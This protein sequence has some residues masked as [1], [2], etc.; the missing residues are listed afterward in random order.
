VTIYSRLSSFAY[1]AVDSLYGMRPNANATHWQLPGVQSHKRWLEILKA[2]YQQNGLYDA[3]GYALYQ[4]GV[5]REALKALRVAGNAAVEFY[6]DTV[7]PGTLPEALPFE[8]DSPKAEQISA[9]IERVWEWSGW[10]AAKQDFVATAAA[11]GDAFTKIVTKTD[12]PPE[13]RRVEYELLDTLWV[14]DFDAD[15]RGF[16]TWIRLDIPTDRRQPDGKLKTVTHTEVWE[17][18]VF[19]VDANSPSGQRR[20]GRFRR[21]EH[22][23]GDDDIERLG[24]PL[25]DRPI[26][27]FGSDSVPVDFIPIGRC[28]FKRRLREKWGVGCYAHAL[29]KL[30]E[31]DRQGTHLYQSLFRNLD[32]QFVL[33]S[34]NAIVDG[35]PGNTPPPKMAGQNNTT[36]D[37]GRLDVGGRR[38]ARV[39]GGWEYVQAIAQLQYDAALNILQ[40]YLEGLKTDLPELRYYDTQDGANASGRA[41]RISLTPAIRRAIEARANIEEAFV[42]LN[43]MALTMGKAIGIPSFQDVGEYDRG[44]FAHRFKER[45]VLPADELEDAQALKAKYEGLVVKTE[46]LKAATDFELEAD[47]YTT[48][49]IARIKREREASAEEA[50]ER[51][52]RALEAA[53]RLPASA[54][55]DTEAEG[56]EA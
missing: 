37:D 9:A 25:E 26:S 2:V 20:I 43:G 34:P 47:G 15:T 56:G 16:L 13:E 8:S 53:P 18:D 6:V 45:D 46:W 52:L 1:N 30:M 11:Y 55:D 28:Q 7:C 36:T 44:D 12:G 17:R 49:D 27:D 48:E 29:E 19:V 41:R 40:D 3:E 31:S 39:P 24:D 42:R 10:S 50:M 5:H 22:D 23:K 21:W 35:R 54:E 51:E 4:S 32:E 38:I 33:Q 14:T